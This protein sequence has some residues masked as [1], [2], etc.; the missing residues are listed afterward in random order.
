MQSLAAAPARVPESLLPQ[1]PEPE[2]EAQEDESRPARGQRLKRVAVLVLWLALVVGL[3]AAFVVQLLLEPGAPPVV[4]T[5]DDLQA[6]IVRPEDLPPGFVLNHETRSTNEDLARY[7]SD[8]ARARALL[9]KWG[10]QGGAGTLMTNQGPPLLRDIVQVAT[11]VERYPDGA[12]AR[13]RFNGRGE[14]FRNWNAN[15]SS[16]RVIKGPRIGDQSA[17]S[18]MYVTDETG[19]ELVVYSVVVRT[20][21][22]VADVT[23]TGY[24]F[25]DDHGR[26]ALQLARLV[27]ERVSA[28]LDRAV[29]PVEDDQPHTPAGALVRQIEQI[30]DDLRRGMRLAQPESMERMIAELERLNEELAAFTEDYAER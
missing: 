29:R 28:Y 12:H 20:G 26:R 25:K 7:F 4:F 8:P 9:D 14:L 1:I 13:Q 15:P 3:P 22:I 2:Q 5:D 17:L 16:T 18:R 24:V 27:D 6:I 19:Q 30:L 11:A 10:R 21:P 23:T